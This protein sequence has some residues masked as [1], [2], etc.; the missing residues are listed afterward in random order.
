[1]RGCPAVSPKGNRKAASKRPGSALN[2]SRILAMCGHCLGRDSVDLPA[3][4]A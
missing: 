3:R 2:V 4:L 1:M